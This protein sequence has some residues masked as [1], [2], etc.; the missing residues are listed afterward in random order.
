[1][2][3][4]KGWEK[5]VWAGQE[6]SKEAAHKW[7]QFFPP[8]VSKQSVPEKEEQEREEERKSAKKRKLPSSVTITTPANRLLSF[9][10][11]PLPSRFRRKATRGREGERKGVEKE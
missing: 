4:G 1:M 8:S 9:L 10:L 2:R 5:W 7:R 3:G 11:L 6:Q